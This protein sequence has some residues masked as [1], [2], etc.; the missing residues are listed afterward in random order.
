MTGRWKG[1]VGRVITDYIHE[2][3]S[4]QTCGCV[5]AN[6]L[7]RGTVNVY[8]MCVRVWV[9]IVNNCRKVT[10]STKRTELRNLT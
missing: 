2:Y 7:L 4:R 5:R 6:V 1:E 10:K 3:H 9:L 8:A